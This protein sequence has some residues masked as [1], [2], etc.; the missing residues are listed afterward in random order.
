MWLCCTACRN[1]DSILTGPVGVPSHAGG[2]SART[3]SGDNRYC[4]VT[5]Y[6]LGRT[7]DFVS[8]R[9]NDTPFILAG[10]DVR[11]F[12][13][14]TIQ[15]RYCITL[16]R[17]SVCI[18]LP[19]RPPLWPYSLLLESVTDP[20]IEHIR[21]Q[22]WRT[23]RNTITATQHNITKLHAF[24]LCVH[25]SRKKKNTRLMAVHPLRRL[26]IIIKPAFKKE[27]RCQLLILSTC[28]IRFNGG[29]SGK[30]K[31]L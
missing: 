8:L 9:A 13:W 29:L 10:R 12:V 31:S 4:T 15:R 11:P 28:K 22:K 26:S 30:P 18:P 7:L 14:A 23:Q 19:L 21:E 16:Q 3:W 20:W 5:N 27:I 24:N 25:T 17:F 2:L 1:Y 6:R